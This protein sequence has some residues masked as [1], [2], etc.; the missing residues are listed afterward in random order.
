MEDEKKKIDNIDLE[1]LL[2]RAGKGNDEDKELLRKLC[3][4]PYDAVN[5]G[6][7]IE[8]SK[9]GNEIA[10][11]I[12]YEE[13]GIDELVHEHKLQWAY[14]WC[15]EDDYDGCSGM[16]G[17]IEFCLSAEEV[18][19][20]IGDS[21]FDYDI[22]S[23]LEVEEESIVSI[24]I[25]HLGCK[26]SKKILETYSESIEDFGWLHDLIEQGNEWALNYLTKCA[27]HIIKYKEDF[28]WLD[29]L[30]RKKG[31][32]SAQYVLAMGYLGNYDFVAENVQLGMRWLKEAAENGSKHAQDELSRMD[33]QAK[34]KIAA[35]LAA[36]ER[37]RQEEA[38]RKAELKIHKEAADALLA[39]AEAGDQ[40]AMVLVAENMIMGAPGYK[41]DLYKAIQLF[42]DA[43]SKGSVD[44][45]E[46]LTADFYLGAGN[47]FEYGNNGVK[48]NLQRAVKFYKI[49]SQKGN[50]DAMYKM[51]LCLIEGR[52]VRNNNWNSGM[53]Y[54]RKAAKA[55]NNKAAAYVDKNDILVNRLLH[56]LIK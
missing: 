25:S 39:K 18:G 2:E 6:R 16:E 42:E 31:N 13:V 51:G 26:T 47:A 56:K 22:C 15:R 11:T 32:A 8:A 46:K 9:S 52:G 48:K 54:M 38:K 5:F 41:H 44:A 3:K 17:L 19:L 12:L 23:Y 7:L 24:C 35:K 27:K 45:S 43:A 28:K 36:K 53:N 40:H 34:E 37:I 33:Q 30:A 49:A 29:N 1:M 10:R 50:T 55:G 14:D 20:D 21:L 4:E